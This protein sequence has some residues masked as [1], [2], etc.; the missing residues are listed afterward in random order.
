VIRAAGGVVT[1]RAPDGRVEVLVVHRP[2]YD[3]WS[4]P[5]GKLEPGESIEDAALREVEEETGICCDLGEPLSEQRYRDR[6]GRPKIVHYFAMT[7]RS[8]GP[9]HANDE[10]DAVRWVAARDAPGLLT[11]D[12]DRELVARAARIAEQEAG[13]S[14]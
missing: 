5:K 12:A 3:D 9:W 11:Y 8:E 13:D 14:R 1:R 7:P 6:H 2:R 4:L 10:I